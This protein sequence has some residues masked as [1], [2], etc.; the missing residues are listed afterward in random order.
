MSASPS[1]CN[2]LG[3]HLHFVAVF[4]IADNV[5]QPVEDSSMLH[6]VQWG[7]GSSDIE[8]VDGRPIDVDVVV[9]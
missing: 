9:M 6:A 5:M 7:G 8:R 1:R 4:A 2:H 3:W